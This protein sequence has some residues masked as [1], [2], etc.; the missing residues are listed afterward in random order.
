MNDIRRM[1]E[2][3]R[4]RMDASATGRMWRLSKRWERAKEQRKYKKGGEE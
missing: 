4:G 3:S 1:L 2:L